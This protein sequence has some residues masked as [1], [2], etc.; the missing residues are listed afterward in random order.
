MQSQHLL[1]LLLL[2]AGT[3][4]A[5]SLQSLPVGDGGPQLAIRPMAP[6]A[7][8]LANKVPAVYYQWRVFGDTRSLRDQATCG[9]QHLPCSAQTR[10]LGTVPTRL[11]T[12][13]AADPAPAR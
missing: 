11:R 4:G 8:E 12:A 1:A 9:P 6:S 2:S 3:V 10:P 13:A 7:Q 5:Q